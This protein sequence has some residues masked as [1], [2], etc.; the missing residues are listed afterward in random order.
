MPGPLRV[1]PLL[2]LLALLPRPA[3]GAGFT[4][5]LPADSA[6]SINSPSRLVFRVANTGSEEGLS[7]LTLRFPSGY[8]VTGGS[9]PPGW[10]VERGAAEGGEIGF[11]T[12]D[13]V[14]CKGAMGPG[15]SLIF[16]VEVTAPA[17]RS[18]TPDT[19][20]SAQAEHS[21]RGVAFDSPV[22]LP[23]WDRLG[24]EAVLIAGPP[25]VGLGR[26]VTV[27]MTVANASTVEL[28]DVSAL[29]NPSGTG[30]VGGLTGPT[31]RSLSLAP[32][33][34]GSM[35]WTG[36]AT[37]PGTVSFGGQAVSPN[38][39]SLPVR[40]DTLSIGDLEVSMSVTPEQVVSGQEVQVQMTVTN[41][42]PVRVAN[43]TP[44]LLAFD[45]TATASGPSGPRPVSLPALEPGES[46]AFAWASTVAGR[47]GD[48]YAFFGSASAEW[49]GIVSLTATSNRGTLA[50]EEVLTGPGKARGSFTMGGAGSAVDGATTSTGGGGQTS[51][52]SG[53]GPT[54]TGTPASGGG[55]S[56]ASPTSAA[57]QFVGVN[58]DGRL[59]GG[60]EFLAGL[61]RY[62]RIIV[63][64]QALSGAHSQRLDLFSPDGSFYQ[65]FSTDFTST[66]VETRLLVGG[67]WITEY[68]LF[69]A[70]RVE[71]YLDRD[72]MPITTGVFVL[73]P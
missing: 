69:G 28:T 46:A 42:G 48:T 20:V 15:S 58:H 19:L 43:A 12:E 4:V 9:A 10:V 57:L 54:S 5:T 3:V 7:R 47:A 31:P 36:R 29:L 35:T 73:T 18:A 2:L 38:V 26:E 59:T 30:S 66:P 60:A 39:A 55:G 49:G 37:A 22:T 41:R 72:T 14:K 70:W 50:Q 27:A 25:I 68:S 65:R 16:R 64:W 51:E 23:S 32:G 11:R 61:T 21:C 45:G 34:S 53:M 63:G 8:L 17:S 71:V 67:T 62:L 24:L 44:S 1:V 6:V 56:A 13:E 52:G 33:G 40:S